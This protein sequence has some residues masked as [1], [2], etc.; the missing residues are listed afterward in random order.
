VVHRLG[1]VGGEGRD[2]EGVARGRRVP[3]L[4][5]RDR[6]GDEPLEEP[7]DV[8]VE[9][10][11]LDRDRRLAGEGGDEVGAPLVVGMTCS[12]TTAGLVSRTAGSRF[13]LISCTTP[14]VSS[15]WVRIGRTSIDF[16]RYPNFSSNE[17]LSR[18][19]TCSGRRY[20]SAIIS[21][22]PV[23]ATYP[24]MLPW[25]IGIVL[26]LKGRSGRVELCASLKCIA[27]G[28]PDSSRSIR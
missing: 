24:A 15:R 28:F 14:I 18:Y 3:R 7:L 16:V 2:A 5:R 22:W 6:G 23:E 12:S 20:T 4:D 11:V 10:A 8:L 21:G 1:E 17:R 26:S 27:A 19:V 25:S 9:P 13:L